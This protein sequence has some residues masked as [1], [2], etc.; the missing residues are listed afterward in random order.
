MCPGHLNRKDWSNYQ[1]LESA[2]TG[3]GLCLLAEGDKSM[4]HS[5]NISAGKYSTDIVLVGAGPLILLMNGIKLQL[6]KDNR[7][8]CLPFAGMSQSKQRS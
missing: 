5:T 6:N 1:N 3:V 4:G 8:A 7:I 2:F